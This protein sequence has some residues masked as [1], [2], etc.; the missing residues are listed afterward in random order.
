MWK[1]RQQLG[2]A[3]PKSPTLNPSAKSFTF[4]P[5]CSTTFVPG[6]A[7]AQYAQPPGPYGGG[8]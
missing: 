2:A 5:G 4:N 8:G 6:G 7:A 3:K 1:V